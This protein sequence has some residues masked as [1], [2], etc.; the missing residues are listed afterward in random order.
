MI[1]VAC[2]VTPHNV[3]DHIQYLQKIAAAIFMVEE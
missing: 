3:A 2:D 1:K